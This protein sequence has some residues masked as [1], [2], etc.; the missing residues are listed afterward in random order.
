ML[1]LDEADF[2]KWTSN[3]TVV[4]VKRE[5]QSRSW[6]I[7]HNI[8]LVISEKTLS[9]YKRFLRLHKRVRGFTVFIIHILIFIGH[10]D[11]IAEI[12]NIIT[13]N[14]NIT[15]LDVVT[16]LAVVILH[17]IIVT[18]VVVLFLVVSPFLALYKLSSSSL[19]LLLCVN[20][21][22]GKRRKWV[23]CQ[24]YNN[25]NSNHDDSLD[26]FLTRLCSILVD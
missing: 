1:K 26:S 17:V 3:E 12:P 20:R 9:F 6:I 10:D 24:N 21:K 4:N 13:N 7:I 23:F 19:S 2:H 16:L 5:I 11:Y 22:Q 25:G 8:L 18:V 14:N 15:T